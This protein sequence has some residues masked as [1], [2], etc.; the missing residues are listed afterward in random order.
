MRMYGSIRRRSLDIAFIGASFFPTIQNVYSQLLP[1]GVPCVDVVVQLHDSGIAVP[2][3]ILES[4]ACLR[5]F[6]FDGAEGRTGL[7]RALFRDACLIL[8]RCWF[9]ICL[10]PPFLRAE[11]A[12]PSIQVVEIECAVNQFFVP[13]PVLPQLFVA[14]NRSQLFDQRILPTSER[15][16]H[17]NRMELLLPCPIASSLRKIAATERIDDLT[18]S[19][20]LDHGLNVIGVLSSRG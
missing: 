8:G 13:F 18:R 11:T 7:F 20:T 12:P 9:Q 5:S 14:K 15:L 3:D 16:L 17:L 1:L 19:R 4:P 10:V 2:E 6:V